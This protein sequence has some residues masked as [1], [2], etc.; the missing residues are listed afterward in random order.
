MGKFKDLTNMKIG[1]LTVIE[2]CGKDKYG[3][4]LWKCKCDCGKEVIISSNK[5][6]CKKPQ[7]YCSSDCECMKYNKRLHLEGQKFGRLIVVKEVE[8]PKHLQ[9]DGVNKSYWLCECE[10]GNTCIVRGNM[11]TSGHTTS[12]GCYKKDLQQKLGKEESYK[13]LPHLYGENNPNYNPNL[14]DEERTLN[15]DTKE[16][17]I[18][19]QQ[20][21]EKA[22]FTCDIC[23]YRG[24]KLRSHHLDGYNWCKERRLD[25]TNGVCLC[26]SCH[27]EFHHI[28]GYGDNT[29][30]QYMK[31]KENNNKDNTEI[32]HEIKAS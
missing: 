9:D 31:F 24:S 12:C 22:N 25:L 5:L 1:H 23:G 26:E 14:T 16:N 6:N 2:Q 20:V 15:R 27:K 32:T 28:Y 21:K 7:K 10:C 29:E 8:K 11:L 3:K 18:W 19:K 17:T 4:I 30:E 13:R